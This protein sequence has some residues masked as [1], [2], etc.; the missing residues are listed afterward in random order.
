MVIFNIS[1][2]VDNEK[3]FCPAKNKML[4]SHCLSVDNV[5]GSHIS[6]K[7]THFQPCISQFV[8]MC[9]ASCVAFSFP[10]L[11][12]LLYKSC[13]PPR[14]QSHVSGTWERSFAL[15]AL[16]TQAMCGVVFPLCSNNSRTSS[17]V[18]GCH[19]A[20]RIYYSHPLCHG[21]SG[22]DV[23][24][25]C[26]AELLPRHKGPG[27]KHCLLWVCVIHKRLGLAPPPRAGDS[28]VLSQS[29]MSSYRE[30]SPV[31]GYR[32]WPTEWVGFNSNTQNID[33]AHIFG[34][35]HSIL[36]IAQ[37]NWK[38]RAFM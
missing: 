32:H 35:K 31:D 28:P 24:C 20:G 27:E 4:F 29:W 22:C 38:R 8:F 34:P 3:R 5:V 6:M 1:E 2:I 21:S 9:L 7:T 13:R 25:K 15:W 23:T 10:F 33:L 11:F 37:R 18:C 36:V 12:F 16:L 19:L 30:H 17:F 26:E 14:R